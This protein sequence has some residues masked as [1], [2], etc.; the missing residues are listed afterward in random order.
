MSD[1]ELLIWTNP[2]PLPPGTGP[3]GEVTLRPGVVVLDGEV[4]ALR[5]NIRRI[6][7]GNADVTEHV[8]AMFDAL[9]GSLDWGSGF[10]SSEEIESILI[11][12]ELAGFEAPEPHHVEL[13]GFE[14]SQEHLLALPARAEWRRK[15]AEAL[16]AWR[17]QIK[18]KAEA[19]RG[20]E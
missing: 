14:S 3:R 15:R 7:I 2:D 10:L 12:A 19:M 4:Q 1:N 20:G 5:Q 17:A 9:I 16:E 13:A 11:V 6:T 18:A 8:A